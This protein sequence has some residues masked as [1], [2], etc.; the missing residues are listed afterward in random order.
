MS[1]FTLTS[2]IQ[3]RYVGYS[4]TDVD[5]EINNINIRPSNIFP[6]NQYNFQPDLMIAAIGRFDPKATENAFDN[7]SEWPSWAIDDYAHEKIAPE[8]GIKKRRIYSLV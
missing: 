1:I 7:Q 4:L 2:P 6:E 8:E 5:A 3:S